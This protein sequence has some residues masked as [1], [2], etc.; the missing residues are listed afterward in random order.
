MITIEREKKQ[1]AAK[2][3]LFKLDFLCTFKWDSLYDAVGKKDAK[4]F[5]ELCESVGIDSP[6]AIALK[7]MVKQLFDFAIG[8]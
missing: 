3:F 1:F 8:W 2:D 5:I 4:D 6:V 7:P